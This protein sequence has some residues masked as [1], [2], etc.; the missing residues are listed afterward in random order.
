MNRQDIERNGELIGSIRWDASECKVDL[1]A[2]LQL[3]E[4]GLVS[5]ALSQCCNPIQT[6]GNCGPRRKKIH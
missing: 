5:L 1:S 4:L 6:Q 2:S 3:D